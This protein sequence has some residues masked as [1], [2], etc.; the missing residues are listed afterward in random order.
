[1]NG[2][3][4]ARRPGKKQVPRLATPTSRERSSGTPVRLGMTERKAKTLARLN[5]R[6]PT[7]SLRAEGGVVFGCRGWGWLVC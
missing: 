1:M 5:A 2:A 7:L 3:P 4:G 6:Y